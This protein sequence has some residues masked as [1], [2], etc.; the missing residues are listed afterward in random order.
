MS[1]PNSEGTPNTSQDSTVSATMINSYIAGETN[2]ICQRFRGYLPVVV[3][4]ETGGFNA[5]NDA[6][7]EVAA[8]ILDMNEKGHL[9][10]VSRYSTHVI[11]FEGANI[12]EKSLAVNGI[13]PWHPLRAARSE[14]AAL[15][16]IFTPIRSAVKETKCNRAILV[17]HNA[18]FDLSFINAAIERTQIKRNPFH[19]FSNFDTVSLA[20]LAYGQTVLSRAAQCAGLDWNSDDAH[21]A[22]YDTMKTAELFCNIVNRWETLHQVTQ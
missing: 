21:S 9:E 3:D 18:A 14:K 20:G 16:Y 5:K 22:A 13:D 19:P 12:D 17:G 8:V 11:P 4:V 10:P 7:L 1:V 2:Q 15:E 6:L